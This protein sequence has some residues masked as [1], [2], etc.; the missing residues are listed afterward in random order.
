VW[1]TDEPCPGCGEPL[2]AGPRGTWRACLACHIA[3]TPAAVLAPYARGDG[4]PQRQ[5]ATQRERDL[6]ALALVRCKG[7]MLA[8]LAELADDDRLTEESR[9][10]VEWFRERVKAA[11][12][13]H[14]L[15]ELAALL[16]DAGIRRRR[17]WHGQ[18]AAITA[19]AWDSDDGEDL[20]HDGEDLDDGEADYPLAIEGAAVPDNAAALARSGYR[21]D[22]AAVDE[23]RCC[24][25][26]STGLSPGPCPGAAA[27]TFGPYQVCERHYQ[28]LTFGSQR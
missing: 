12:S 25:E 23:G 24:I 16:P 2:A 20:G 13:G 3:A 10:V 26:A 7:I 14:R 11:S 19:P 4:A 8:E 18:P 9:P 27:Q 28:A 22:P 5:V 1:V 17:W 15:D 21:A 6:A